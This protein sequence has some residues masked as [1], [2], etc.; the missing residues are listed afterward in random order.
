MLVFGMAIVGC[1]NGST[2]GESDVWTNVIAFSQLDGTWKAPASATYNTEEGIN[3]SASFT[4]YFLTFN[5]TN[6]IVLYSGTITQTYSGGN[7]ASFWQKKKESLKTTNSRITDTFND[8]NYS[9]TRT[10][11]NYI[12]TLPEED[13]LQIGAQINQNGTK[14]KIISETIFYKQ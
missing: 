13:I 4:N 6:K 9:H 3:I 5:S 2:D 1:D 11:N 10:F 12:V 14:I 7:V 8:S